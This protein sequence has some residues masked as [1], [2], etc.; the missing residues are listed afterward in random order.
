M[1]TATTF[2][3]AF[4]L[5]AASGCG[6]TRGSDYAPLV[7]KKGADTTQIAVDTAEC[8][9]LAKQQEGIIAEKLLGA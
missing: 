1:K 3:F 6:S 8:Q 5:I 7:D 2:A 4:A 9:K